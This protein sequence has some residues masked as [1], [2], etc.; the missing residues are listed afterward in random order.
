[1]SE[2]VEPHIRRD[3]AEGRHQ[4][5]DATLEMICEHGVGV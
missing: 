5:L 2:H 4:I 3:G 1:M